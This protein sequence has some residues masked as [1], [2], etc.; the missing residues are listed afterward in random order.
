M[1]HRKNFCEGLH[2]KGLTLN[3]TFKFIINNKPED[4]LDGTEDLDAQMLYKD[5]LKSSIIRKKHLCLSRQGVKKYIK[6][7]D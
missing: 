5:L 1:T 3:K 7:F 4:T 2:T 6:R